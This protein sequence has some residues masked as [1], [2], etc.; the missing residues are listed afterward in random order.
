MNEKN[1][2]AR[3]LQCLAG[4]LTMVLG[5][6]TT[7]VTY[8]QP[9]LN[10]APDCAQATVTPAILD[11][12]D[13]RMVEVDIS[14]VSDPEGQ[15][16]TLS[17]QCILQT[18]PAVFWSDGS[19]ISG[20]AS[21]LG[22]SSPSVRAKRLTGFI[23]NTTEEYYRTNGR[24][25]EI[26]FKATDSEGA[27]CSGL[28]T[29]EA[30]LFLGS[31]QYPDVSTKDFG[32][33]FPA[34][35]GGVNC[36]A[37]SFNN[38]PIIYS[39]A[40]LTVVAGENYSYQ[41]MGHDPDQDVLTYDLVAPEGATINSETGLIS[42]V[43]TPEQVGVHNF[44]VTAS[45][46][47]GLKATQ[48]IVVEVESPD[49]DVSVALI[50]NP[51]SGL[52][53]LTV[54][55]SPSVQNNNIVITRFQWD[56]DG[57]GVIDRNNQFGDPQTF[58]YIG[59]AGSTFNAKLI[60][61]LSNGDTVSA[62]KTITLTNEPPSVQVSTN[63]TNGHAPLSVVFNVAATDPQGIQEV[64]I[65]YESDGIFDAVVSVDEGGN[66]P[67]LFDTTYNQ[68]GNFVATVK[69]VDALGLSTV[70]SNSGI[71]VDVNNPL[72]PIISISG[73]PLSGAPPLLANLSATAELFDS[74][75]ISSWQWDLDGDGEFETDGGADTTSLVSY[76][77]NGVNNYFPAVEVTSTTGR[78]ATASISVVTS[79]PL[80]PSLTIPNSS[81]TL[82]IDANE[83]ADFTVTMPFE[84]PLEIWM[85]NA[86]GQRV[87]TIRERSLVA[88]GAHPFVWDGTNDDGEPL[89]EGDY[90]VIIGYEKYE[91]P[92]E[93]D[94]RQ[95]TGGQRT[96]YRRD[97]ANPRTFDRLKQPINIEYGV[98]DPAA[99][100][101]FWQVSFGERLMTL[102]E[103][104]PLG[105]GRYSLLWNGEYPNGKKLPSNVINLM[106]GILRNTLADNVIFVKEDPRIEN[107]T[108]RSTI[109]VDPRREPITMDITLS[110]ESDIE[111]VV[112]D[113][114]KGVDVAN[115]VFTGLAVG[116]QALIWDA[117]NDQGQL[118]APGDYRIGLRSVD[119][120]GRRSLFWYR[121][122]RIDY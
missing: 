15:E 44:V 71:R 122:Q 53:P 61:T 57:D 110:K 115:R 93:V 9:L 77:Y 84:S 22:T 66:G 108:L 27:S 13:D 8:A 69:V 28:V 82:S 56:F 64:S 34:V 81:D 85:E 92:Q 67:W 105:R 52:S 30:P 68:E 32:M 29:V 46:Q 19:G 60:V 5:G 33:R 35:G 25:Y 95:T 4:M 76:T 88:S 47:G 42:W 18:E 26:I 94:L 100:T 3:H 89:S 16:V 107:F 43:P 36:E 62:F 20:D 86:S 45:D 111:L 121:T 104:V 80:T 54:R 78:K 39:Q 119:S 40:P 72:D 51:D 59:E 7:S 103:Q 21:G 91:L 97:K 49:V 74:S 101:F 41:V 23:I 118:L 1:C 37:E 24:F 79:S 55:F 102:L 11:P 48:E 83:M 117:K 50:A 116:E 90:Y 120:M 58:T 106:P 12:A 112:S 6:A 73:T 70:V 38:P 63:V 87:K 113:M 96:Y 65:D 31:H 75:E 14:G 10:L 98:D 99:V 109:V 114:E 2:R 17:A